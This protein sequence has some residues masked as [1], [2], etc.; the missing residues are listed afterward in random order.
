[1]SNPFGFTAR[2]R[3]AES[4]LMFYRA[5]YY[6]P[7]LGR[8]ISQDPIGFDGGDLNLYRYVFNDPANLTDPSGE[9]ALAEYAATIGNRVRKAGSSI[10]RYYRAIREGFEKLSRLQKAIVGGG[11]GAVSGGALGAATGG[12]GC[13]LGTGIAGGA[14]GGASFVAAA[15]LEALLAGSAGAFAAGFL[16]YVTCNLFIAERN[17]IE[18]GPPSPPGDY[19]EPSPGGPVP[20]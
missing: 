19:H 17:L 2:E 3:D 7:K 13:D 15:E 20:T 10:F 8:F 16:F 11:V 14:G 6:D 5:R 4:G 1:V 18:L 9:I 12:E